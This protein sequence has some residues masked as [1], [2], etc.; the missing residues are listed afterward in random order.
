MGKI[1]VKRKTL[2]S[3]GHGGRAVWGSGCGTRWRLNE[4]LNEINYTIFS[5]MFGINLR[6]WLPRGRQSK[7][8]Y[9]RPSSGLDARRASTTRVKTGRNAHRSAQLFEKNIWANIIFIVLHGWAC[10][11]GA[12]A[13]VCVWV[14]ERRLVVCRRRR[15]PKLR[16]CVRIE[17]EW[18]AFARRQCA[19][20]Q[21]I[22][23]ECLSSAPPQ[24]AW[25]LEMCRM[26][27]HIDC[28]LYILCVCNLKLRQCSRYMCGFMCAPC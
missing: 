16:V 15:Q 5:C 8:W 3:G 22:D 4:R 18:F 27:K 10:G 13:R 21:E 20:W 19:L 9:I 24:T 11:P 6:R 7:T 17:F 2:L 14:R 25:F 23:I 12:R 28:V 1:R 26:C